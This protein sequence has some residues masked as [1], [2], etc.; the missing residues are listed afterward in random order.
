MMFKTDNYTFKKKM[1]SS[2]T[3]TQV[4]GAIICVNNMTLTLLNYSN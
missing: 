4:D 3:N 2:R 1:I